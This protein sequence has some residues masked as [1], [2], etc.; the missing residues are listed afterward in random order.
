VVADRNDTRGIAKGAESSWFLRFKP[1]SPVSYWPEKRAR[2]MKV[3]GE[4]LSTEG[5]GSLIFVGL[6][7][8]LMF[9]GGTSA[10]AATDS[11][12]RVSPESHDF[13]AVKRLGGDVHTTFAVHNQ[14]ETP[15]KIR[16]IWTS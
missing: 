10:R 7:T 13:G 9:V 14:G 1:G 11:A 16:R 5:Y 6:F 8:W 2:I 3:M 15:T 4:K 12:L